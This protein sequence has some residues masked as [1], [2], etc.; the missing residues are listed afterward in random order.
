M[1]PYTLI[2]CML[3]VASLTL[4]LFA[5]VDL[6]RWWLEASTGLVIGGMLWVALLLTLAL[7]I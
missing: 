5:Y 7:R 1:N 2:A 6:E 3:I 4:Y